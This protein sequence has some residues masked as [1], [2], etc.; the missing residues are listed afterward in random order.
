M[1]GSVSKANGRQMQKRKKLDKHYTGITCKRMNEIPLICP[2]CKTKKNVP[3]QLAYKAGG[4]PCFK[5]SDSK[6]NPPLIVK[7]KHDAPFKVGPIRT[8]ITKK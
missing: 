6:Q 2:V 4:N 1:A 5:C 3:S 7:F 8:K